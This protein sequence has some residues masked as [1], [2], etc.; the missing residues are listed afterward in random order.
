MTSDKN[1]KITSGG[2]YYTGG[3]DRAGSGIS[4]SHQD[5]EENSSSDSGIVSAPT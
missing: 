2:F 5:H 1:T 4:V 3:I